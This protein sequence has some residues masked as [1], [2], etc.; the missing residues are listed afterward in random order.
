MFELKRR[1]WVTL[2]PGDTSPSGKT[3]FMCLVCG[4]ISATPDKTCPILACHHGGMYYVTRGVPLLLDDHEFEA[5][6]DALTQYV[7]NGEDALDE[8]PTSPLLKVARQQ[9]EHARRIMNRMSAIMEQLSRDTLDDMAEE[10][11][12][13][14]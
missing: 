2:P 14:G 8:E 4:R 7:E 6:M 5:V 1:S 3:L 9:V 10:R 12:S 11:K 13:D